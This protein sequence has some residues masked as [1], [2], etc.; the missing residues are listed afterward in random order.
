MSDGVIGLP[1]DGVGKKLDTESLDVG[2]TTVQRERIILAGLTDTALAYVLAT[3]PA[4]AAFAL[5][6]RPTGPVAPVLERLSSTDLAV[7]GSAD[8]DGTTFVS[9]GL[10]GKLVAVTLASSVACKWDIKTLDGAIEV[11]KDTVYTSGLWGTPSMLWTP[12]HKEFVT[13]DHA[14]GDE[15][16]RVTAENLDVVAADVRVTLYWDEA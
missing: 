16:F 7:G 2:G 4:A 10:T 13:I 9:S 8:L 6:V 5:P 12:P 15:G 14:T 3:D 1:V 11:T